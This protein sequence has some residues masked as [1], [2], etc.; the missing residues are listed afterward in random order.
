MSNIA[1]HKGLVKADIS[2]TA[3]VT[4]DVSAGVVG[5]TVKPTKSIGKHFVLSSDWQKITEGGKSIAITLKTE[6]DTSAAHIYKY[7][8]DW[9]MTGSGARTFD[10]YAPDASTGSLYLN[11]E[12][13]LQQPDNLMMVEGGKGDAQVASWTLESHGTVTLAAAV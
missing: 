5:F 12:F 6:I 2:S 11:G 1:Q 13:Y 9:L 8:Y 7:M 10:F 4:T 3:T